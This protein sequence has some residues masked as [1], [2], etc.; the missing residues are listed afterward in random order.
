[1]RPVP[2]PLTILLVLAGWLPLSLV[3]QT[4]P[5]T[6]QLR[7]IHAAMFTKAEAAID[8]KEY[9]K[10]EMLYTQLIDANANPILATL[11]RAQARIAQGDIKGA[12]KDYQMILKQYPTQYQALVEIGKTYGA[13]GELEKAISYFDKAVAADSTHKLGYA[14][15]GMAYREM[16]QYEPAIWNYTE[17]LRRDSADLQLR[18]YR[19]ECYNFSH[20]SDLAQQDLEFIIRIDSTH[21]LA[22]TNLAFSLLDQGLYQEAEIH[23]KR[24]QRIY[25]GDQYILNNYGFLKHKLGQTEEG[26][27]LIRRALI[28]NPDNSYAYKYRALIYLDQGKTDEACQ[29]IQTALKMGYTE[30]YGPDVSELKATYCD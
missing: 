23:Y 29:A 22:L 14:Y 20:Q 11:G 5:D 18:Y 3:A 8:A 6:I 28:V 1:M 26:L 25:P 21:R 2:Y 24:L 16:K 13:T 4:D 15:R 7:P 9:T 17:S 19:A 12:R 27:E 10:A 30:K